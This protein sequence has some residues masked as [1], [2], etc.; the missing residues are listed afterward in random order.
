MRKTKMETKPRSPHGAL[1]RD[2]EE[3]DRG[4]EQRERVD[5]PPPTV[6][7]IAGLVT[8]MHMAGRPQ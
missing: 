4:L 5:I 2:P 1:T 3:V 7:R 6:D 8:D